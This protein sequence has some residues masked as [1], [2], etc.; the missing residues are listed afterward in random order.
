MQYSSS[1]AEQAVGSIMCNLATISAGRR[2]HQVSGG[3]SL[4]FHSASS[5]NDNSKSMPADLMIDE[6]V[7]ELNGRMLRT[8]LL[9]IKRIN[10]LVFLTRK[11]NNF[12]SETL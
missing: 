6:T 10:E 12:L 7:C 8:T 11:E 5:P 3:L 2:G 1:G 9:A 4:I